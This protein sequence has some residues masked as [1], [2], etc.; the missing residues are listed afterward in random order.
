MVTAFLFAFFV[1]A[2]R[3]LFG[4]VKDVKG[5]VDF[6]VSE[7]KRR[8]VRQVTDLMAEEAEQATP[9]A[10]GVDPA[11]LGR[12][13]QTD[14][15]RRA[16]SATQE[17]WRVAMTCSRLLANM[18]NL[19][20]L[21]SIGRLFC[22]VGLITLVGYALLILFWLPEGSHLL[23]VLTILMW[24]AP[25]IVVVGVRAACEVVARRIGSVQG[26]IEEP[27]RV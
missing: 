12:A 5:S 24:G 10:W 11:T 19:K 7:A 23:W 8:T 25:F 17:Q 4:E 1:A 2:F 14:R 18:G 27:W 6:A 16:R 15:E 20:A 13:M 3:G 22:L 21:E 9:P 26:E